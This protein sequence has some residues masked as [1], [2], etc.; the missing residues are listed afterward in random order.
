M[1]L[2]RADPAAVIALTEQLIAIESHK[3][4]PGR[5]TAVGRFLEGWF[6]ERGIDARLEPVV[7][8]RA[9]VIVRVGGRSGPT[10]L[11]NGH[12]D[13][14]PAG[15][16]EN[17]F[18][19]TIRDGI[20][21]GRGACDMKGAIAAMCCA[22]ASI[23]TQADQLQGELLFVG[24]VDEETGGLG[25]KA[26][27]ESGL[28]ADYAVVGEP[29]CLRIAV[30]H[31]GSCFVRVTLYGKGAHGSCPEK[32]VSAVRGAAQLV[33]LLEEDLAV[34]LQERTHPLL[35][36]STVSI[37]RVCGGSQP[38]IV[39]EQCEIDIDRRTLPG[40]RDVLPEVREYVE[41]VC[42]AI[43]GL[44][45]DIR[46]MAMTAIVPHT[47]LSTPVDSPLAVAA[48]ESARSLGLPADPVGVTYWTDGG[49]L[50]ANGIE[51]I[52]VGPGDIANAH[53][54]DDQ[55]R[56]EELAQAAALYAGIVERLI[57]DREEKESR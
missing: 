7:D 57:V 32:G 35:G 38:N 14:V 28:R 51:T 18:L 30:G 43:P 27:L 2:H 53:G 15:N 11:L 29:T 26:L 55:V 22:V 8:D 50:G 41:S 44:S 42:R 39:A 16:M 4:V 47:P 31:K 12:V 1:P 24:T 6:R 5:E 48:I 45:Y 9:N 52:V 37:G 49:H 36:Q 56:V 21:R 13:T 40:E 17:A 23:A 10:V 19:P 3:A 33:R 54:P 34:Q 20:L 46:E 25:V